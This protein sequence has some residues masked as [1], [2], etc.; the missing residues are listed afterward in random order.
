MVSAAGDLRSWALLGALAVA[1]IAA[2]PACAPSE[3]AD[4]I[5]AAIAA[6]LADAGARVVLPALGELR[7][8]A[9]ALST[10]LADAASQPE[11]PHD[12]AREAWRAAMAAWQ[13]VEVFQIGALADPLLA[14]AGEG[15]SARF[16]AWPETNPCRVDQELVAAAWGSPTFFDD[17]LP[18]V[19]G[20]A[21]L[22]QLLF[23]AD[24]ENHCPPQVDINAEGTWAALSPA[25]LAQRRL[26]YAAAL[27]RRL[28]ADAAALHDDWDP[29]G[30]DFAGALARA[31][32]NAPYTSPQQGV[33]ALFDALFFTM[34][35]VV[36]LKLDEP[37]GLGTC[38]TDCP[39]LAESP[40]AGGSTA[41][42]T[43]NLAAVRSLLEGGDGVGLLDL[44]TTAGHD[45]VVAAVEAALADAEAAAAAVT[46]DVPV[47]IT[48]DAAD[49]E[50]LRA[51]LEHLKEAIEDDLRAALTLQIPSE[52]AGDND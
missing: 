49:L 14:P 25:E 11:S 24:D 40:L 12:E 26:D 38:T 7:D 22:E 42:L 37:M 45:D 43:L 23:P 29:A 16:Y 3:D 9:A 6:T 51:A 17:T 52:A 18:N 28:A 2:P 1:A 21:A 8:A 15:R 46:A 32:D 31:G 35:R 27:G 39:G 33:Q 5:D 10:A 4:P 34:F 44:A 13:T 47:A 19:H 48:D 30:G 50:A 41:W 36:R 20:L